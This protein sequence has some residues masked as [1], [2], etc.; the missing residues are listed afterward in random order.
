MAETPGSWNSTWVC[1]ASHPS[2][3]GLGGQPW[4]GLL[5]QLANPQPP[6]QPDPQVSAHCAPEGSVAG[7]ASS[8]PRRLR[9]ALSCVQGQL[10]GTWAF[11]SP[12]TGATPCAL[13]STC[14]TNQTSWKK[15]LLIILTG[16]D[17]HLYLLSSYP[18]VMEHLRADISK[19]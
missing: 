7:S 1:M 13:P 2:P 17:F 14:Q 6:L 9:A 3:P 16:L 10:P 15:S 5:L 18:I 4:L 19:D 11:R 8:Q 12:G